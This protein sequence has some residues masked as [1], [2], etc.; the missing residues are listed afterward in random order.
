MFSVVVKK[1]PVRLEPEPP[2]LIDIDP[3]R[4]IRMLE[5]QITKLEKL[6]PKDRDAIRDVEKYVHADVQT[7]FGNTSQE[8]G[9]VWQQNML[10]DETQ[11]YLGS[12][13]GG[14]DEYD[15][16][17]DP[18]HSRGSSPG[19]I[20]RAKVGI[21]KMIATV[22]RLLERARDLA[23]LRA[24]EGEQSMNPFKALPHEN[25]I[26]IKPNGERLPFRAL[27]SEGCV[28]VHN[29]NFRADVGDKIERRL[30]NGNIENYEVAKVRFEKGL[31][32]IPDA[33]HIDIR[34]LAHRPAAPMPTPHVIHDHSTNY[35]IHGSTIAAVGQNA[36]VASSHVIGHATQ[37]T[38]LDPKTFAAVLALV[39]KEL[40]ATAGGDGAEAEQASEDLA[41]VAAANKAITAKDEPDE[42]GFKGAMKKI[43]ATGLKIV[44]RVATTAAIAYLRA[45][46]LIPPAPHH[47]LPPGE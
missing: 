12:L 40:A 31:R 9:T 34:D 38:G 32:P 20:A 18:M 42:R 14:D 7:V 16:Y 5:V 45:H 3:P 41:H 8:Y 33:Y 43:S 10:E 47:E 17:G 46:G 21:E 11:I 15:P 29:A 44:E 2:P 25:L 37:S 1:G 26:L 23:A 35:N 24:D 28:T 13:G 4:A 22:R 30:P 39:R 36:T 6:D 27:W 19:A